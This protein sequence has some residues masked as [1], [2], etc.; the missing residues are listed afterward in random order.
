MTA[1]KYIRILS[2]FTGFYF[3]LA[4]GEALSPSSGKNNYDDKIE[5][6]NNN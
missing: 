3:I 2:K 4:F 1:T 6:E 5:R